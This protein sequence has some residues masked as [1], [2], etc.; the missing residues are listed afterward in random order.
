MEVVVERTTKSEKRWYPIVRALYKLQCFAKHAAMA[1]TYAELQK[2]PV[3]ER[4]SEAV[5][6]T[7]HGVLCGPVVILE[8]ERQRRLR[9]ES[10]VGERKKEKE[11]LCF[12]LVLF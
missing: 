4:G 3:W 7:S 11:E 2:L 1:T 12:G 8:K 5:F 6:V 10:L 9:G